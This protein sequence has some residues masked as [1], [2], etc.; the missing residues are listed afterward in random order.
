M[1]SA[2]KSFNWKK[3][4]WPAKCMVF[5]E[6]AVLKR[7]PA[8]G[9]PLTSLNLRLVDASYSQDAGSVLAPNVVMGLLRLLEVD[10]VSVLPVLQALRVCSSIPEGYGLGSSAALSLA[11]MEWCEHKGWVRWGSDAERFRWLMHLESCVQGASSGVD[12][13]FSAGESPLWANFPC[14]QDL[15]EVFPPTFVKPYGL[16]IVDVGR[17]SLPNASWIPEVVRRMDEAR[18]WSRYQALSL[19]GAQC[20]IRGDTEGL[21]Q[22]LISLSALQCDV[23]ILED[24]VRRIWLEHPAVLGLKAL[25]AGGGGALLLVTEPEQ[26]Q[27]IDQ[28]VIWRGRV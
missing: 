3:S 4:N 9:F 19:V 16:V 11:L 23:G 21:Q 26:A 14:H 17:R 13:I 12:L 28:D 2:P 7:K 8:L 25:G 5:G 20:L 15:P 22:T 27:D 6:Y 1:T 24:R 10:D 18:V